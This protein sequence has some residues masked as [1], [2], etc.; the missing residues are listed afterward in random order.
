MAPI[1]H[2]YKEM[3]AR[4]ASDLHMVIGFPPLIRIRGELFP[5]DAP[6][7]TPESNQQLL[8]EILGREQ[9]QQLIENN[10]AVQNR[11]ELKIESRY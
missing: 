7:L 11:S 8:F 6:A 9:Q 3:K 10:N 1:D 4:G 2:F 5:L